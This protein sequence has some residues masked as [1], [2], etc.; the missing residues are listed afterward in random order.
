MPLADLQ[1]GGSNVYVAWLLEHGYTDYQAREALRERAPLESIQSL[2][3]A[4]R[5]GRRAWEAGNAADV[6]LAGQRIP[7]GQTPQRDAAGRGLAY[8]VDVNICYAS[9]NCDQVI[10]MRIDSP[11]QLTPE[12]VRQRAVDM[13]RAQQGAAKPLYGG[14]IESA[15]FDVGN[16]DFL[17][18]ER[19]VA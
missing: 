11:S 12:E 18:V 8:W 3:A 9:G 19:V 1:A 10:T 13:L 6:T 2:E 4:V 15:E 16:I 5:H 14:Y 17:A 7:I